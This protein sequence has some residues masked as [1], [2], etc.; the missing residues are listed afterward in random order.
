MNAPRMDAP[1]VLDSHS[2]A[3][4]DVHGTNRRIID[5]PT[6]RRCIGKPGS[7]EKLAELMDR[8]SR[9]ESLWNDSD[10]TQAVPLHTLEF[11]Q[12]VCMRRGVFGG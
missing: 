6:P 12:F 10:P 5:R 2:S 3:S 11:F 4:S 8:R 1:S 9:G 7:A